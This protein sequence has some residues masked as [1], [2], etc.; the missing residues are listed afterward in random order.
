ML[1]HWLTKKLCIHI[2]D[3]IQSGLAKENLVESNLNILDLFQKDQERLDNNELKALRLIAKRAH[4]SNFFDESDV[5]DLINGET[6]AS[7]LHKRLIIRSGA[8]YNIGL[9]I[10]KWTINC[11]I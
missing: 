3:Q 10:K 9:A 1:A 8:N 11:E 4:E 5:G 2:F 6:I 7:L